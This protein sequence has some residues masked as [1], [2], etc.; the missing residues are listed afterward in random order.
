MSQNWKETRGENKMCT[1]LYTSIGGKAYLSQ[2]FHLGL[3]NECYSN[4][5]SGASWIMGKC[6]SRSQ[7]ICQ[8]LK[9]WLCALRLTFSFYSADKPPQ[10]LYGC[11]QTLARQSY[12]PGRDR[13]QCT[14][15]KEEEP[16]LG[17]GQ[18]WKKSISV[19]LRQ[20]AKG[21]RREWLCG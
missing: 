15:K 5:C 1:S 2:F 19:M 9:K 21:G 16:G 18:N 10:Q 6:Y 4:I 20:N 11:K 17:S 13:G 3:W 12:V 8:A 7:L 14:G